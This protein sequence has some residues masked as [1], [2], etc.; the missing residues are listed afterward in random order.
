M[1]PARLFGHR[2][3]SCV[4]LLRSSRL[5]CSFVRP[6]TR[7]IGQPRRAR[8]FPGR[9]DDDRR[10][11]WSIEESSSRQ[12]QRSVP[13][14]RSAANGSPY[15][16]IRRAPLS[17]S[18]WRR[19]G[20]SRRETSPSRRVTAR[21]RTRPST[22]RSP[23]SNSRISCTRACRIRRGS[24]A[25]G[26]AILAQVQTSISAAS[27][28]PTAEP[29]SRSRRPMRCRRTTSFRSTIRSR[30]PR[31]VR[32]RIERR[33]TCTADTCLGSAM[34]ARIRGSIRAAATGQ[35]PVRAEPR[36]RPSIP[37]SRPDR[38]SII[39]LTT[40][41]PAG[42]VPRSRDRHHPPQCV[43]GDRHVRMSSLMGTRSRWRRR[44]QRSGAA[45]PADEVP[46]VPGQ[47]LRVSEIAR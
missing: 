39:T 40:R 31:R 36:T 10:K 11:R 30:A 24:G 29:R 35:A 43:C 17:R 1:S 4:L 5:A 28:L 14:S 3:R 21:A 12:P 2:F 41:A 38:P 37:P 25:T 6:R 44:Q 47:D 32:P 45:R 20:T 19:C 42:L 7:T 23:S 18:S 15:G 16:P 26:P 34:A 8:R 46:G 22:I 33:F 13:A 27:S 9:F